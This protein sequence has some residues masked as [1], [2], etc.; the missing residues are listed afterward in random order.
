LNTELS[1]LS[2]LVKVSNNWGTLHK[3]IPFFLFHLA[4]QPGN[5]RAPF[6]AVVPIFPFNR[7]ANRKML[8]V[9][10]ILET[11]DRE[12]P[13][14]YIRNPLVLLRLLAFRDLLEHAVEMGRQPRLSVRHGAPEILRGNRLTAYGAHL[15]PRPER[16]NRS[17]VLRHFPLKELLYS[18]LKL[19][20]LAAVLNRALR[21]QI[22]S[23]ARF[24]LPPRLLRIPRFPCFPSLAASTA[25]RTSLP[26][27]SAPL[28]AAVAVTSIHKA[29]DEPVVRCPRQSS[30]SKPAQSAELQS[31]CNRD[32]GFYCATPL[33]VATRLYKQQIL[34]KH[35]YELR[36]SI[37]NMIDRRKP[38]HIN[39]QRIEPDFA[40]IIFSII[41]KKKFSRF[42]NSFLFS[43]AE[44]V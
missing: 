28:S 12:T 41:C 40:V 5:L 11:D 33:C 7:A 1:P 3:R 21:E 18:A 32:S 42:N 37:L 39:N 6:G 24:A 19:A 27:S 17:I 38:R 26:P 30:C 20:L 36:E 14:P 22:F 43:L 34:M 29:S 25:L 31:Q 13:L 16:T 4:E 44:L 2:P 35:S 8:Q 23:P 15:F 10:R 9:V